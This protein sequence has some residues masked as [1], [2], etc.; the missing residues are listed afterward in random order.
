MNAQLELIS[1]LFWNY[2]ELCLLFLPTTMTI[3]CVRVVPSLCAFGGTDINVT[4]WL[5]NCHEVF[6]QKAIGN[7]MGIL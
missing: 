3:L 6:S 4:A 5:E 2:Y 1:L 7:T